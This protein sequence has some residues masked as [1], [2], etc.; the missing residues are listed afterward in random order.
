MRISA[1]W[2]ILEVHNGALLKPDWSSL[3]LVAPSTTGAT[4]KG[5]GWTL[6]LKPNWKIVP[7][8]RNGDFTLA[9]PTQ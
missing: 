4:L 7:G 2:G 3:S 5:D 9:G 6:E 8:A 1:D